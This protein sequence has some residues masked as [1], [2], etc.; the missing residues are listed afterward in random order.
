MLL[1]FGCFPRE[2]G[3]RGAATAIDGDGLIGGSET[4]GG[5]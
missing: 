1:F 3:S 4:V 2:D 5:G